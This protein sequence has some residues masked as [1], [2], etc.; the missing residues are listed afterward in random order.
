[1]S[2]YMIQANVS[3]TVNEFNY[4]RQVPTFFLDKNLLGIVNEKHAEA[5]ACDII[6]PLKDEKIRVYMSVRFVERMD[7]ENYDID[8]DRSKLPIIQSNQDQ[9][10][11]TENVH[12]DS[13]VAMSYLPATEKFPWTWK[14]EFIS[15]TYR[16]VD[17]WWEK[18][19]RMARVYYGARRGLRHAK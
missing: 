8:N 10:K 2:G 16:D 4:S 17:D 3:T 12:E 11:A 14:V 5:I 18:Q 9:L 6:N 7:S 1:M 15:D 13:L 19:P